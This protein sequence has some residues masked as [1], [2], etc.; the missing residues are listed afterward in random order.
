MVTDFM[1]DTAPVQSLGPVG[2][3]H[4]GLGPIGRAIA[5]IV[6]ERPL[7]RSLGAVDS[8]P[9]MIGQRLASICR[10][11]SD[12]NNLSVKGSIDAKPL[13][14]VSVVLHSTGSSLAAIAPQLRECLELGYN[15]ISTCEELAFPWGRKDSLASDLDRLARTHGV[16]LLGTGINPGFAMDCLPIV[17]SYVARNVTNIAVSRRQD[18]GV[19]RLPLQRK[20]GAGLT[21]E[22]FAARAAQRNI[23]HVGLPESAGSLARAFGWSIGDIEETLEPV[24]AVR[25]LTTDVGPIHAGEVTGLLQTLKAFDGPQLL[26]SLTLT[27]AVQLEDPGDDIWLF[28]DPD[29]HASIPGGLHGDIGTAAIVVNSI[30]G[31]MA[32]RPGL[33]LMQDLP[34]ASPRVGELSEAYSAQSMLGET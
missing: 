28:G 17:L 1:T 22:E 12:A 30:Q 7:L 18:A 13:L 20:V 23:G 6:A 16:R 11:P 26:I 4:Y 33:R 25:D 5:E 14:G 10:L 29:I 27:M 3:I 31:L 15:V 21:A 2:V 24:L 32:C 19:R 34:V 8:D 9:G